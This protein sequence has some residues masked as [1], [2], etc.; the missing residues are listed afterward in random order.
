[1]DSLVW[2]LWANHSLVQTA[3]WWLFAAGM[4]LGLVGLAGIMRGASRQ[5]DELIAAD[6]PV[7]DEEMLRLADVVG[8]R[9]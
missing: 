3:G 1:M 8:V 7:S 4:L 2:W 5:V 9:S 6:A